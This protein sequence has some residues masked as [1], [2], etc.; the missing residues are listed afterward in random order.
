MKKETIGKLGC[1]IMTATLILATIA[2]IV[3]LTSYTAKSQTIEVEPFSPFLSLNGGDC[4]METGASVSTKLTKFA[5]IGAGLHYLVFSEFTSDQLRPEYTQAISLP[6]T[7][8]SK[9]LANTSAFISLAPMLKSGSINLVSKAG[10]KYIMSKSE[11]FQAY[12]ILDYMIINYNNWQ[13]V[14][15]VGIGFS[16]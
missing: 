16:L 13:G 14:V 10:L 5:D 1:V 12:T 7:I 6:I 9:P 8:M 15:Q 3:A 2:L 11:G 4:G